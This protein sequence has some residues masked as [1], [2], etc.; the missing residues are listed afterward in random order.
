MS[1]RKEEC[2]TL[3]AV[4]QNRE[5]ETKEKRI[6]AEAQYRVFANPVGWKAEESLRKN[7]RAIVPIGKE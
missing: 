1:R 6:L 7:C 4:N 5:G 2:R 3:K